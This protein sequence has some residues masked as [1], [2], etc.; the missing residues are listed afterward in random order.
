MN[1]KGSGGAL[2]SVG[3]VPA[4]TATTVE[5][6]NNNESN[7]EIFFSSVVFAEDLRVFFQ[8]LASTS[9]QCWAPLVASSLLHKL[10]TLLLLA[11]KMDRASTCLSGGEDRSLCY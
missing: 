3:D 10:G 7:S 11:C 4:S 5:E 2:L 1:V 8:S 6:I 9:S